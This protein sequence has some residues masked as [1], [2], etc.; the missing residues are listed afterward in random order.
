MN[1]TGDLPLDI[2]VANL[3]FQFIVFMK[4]FSQWNVVFA[5]VT[6]ASTILDRVLHH[7]AVINIKGKSYCLTESPT[8]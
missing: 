4:I 1:E 7:C 3:F 2:E 5:D 6:I 8:P